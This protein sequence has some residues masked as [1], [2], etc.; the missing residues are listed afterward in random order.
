MKLYHHKTGGGAEYLTDKFITAPNGE[1]EG[2]FKGSKYIVR[3]DGDIAKD[4]EL[5][6]DD[7]ITKEQFMNYF[8]SD[9]YNQELSADDCIEVFQ[10]SLKG[11]SDITFE[12][13]DN[14]CNDYGVNLKELIS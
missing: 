12:L 7:S 3:I 14:L 9:N 4:A 2:V 1:K 6:F 8:R 11:Q 10:T 5:N 13:L